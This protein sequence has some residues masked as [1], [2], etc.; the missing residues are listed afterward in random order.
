MHSSYATKVGTETLEQHE[1]AAS[2][3]VMQVEAPASKL[4]P[5][6]QPLRDSCGLISWCDVI[7]ASLSMANSKRNSS[8]LAQNPGDTKNFCHWGFCYVISNSSST[9]TQQTTVSRCSTLFTPAP[10][11]YLRRHKTPRNRE[12][13]HVCHL[14]QHQRTW[15]YS[16]QGDGQALAYSNVT[17]ALPGPPNSAIVATY[18]NPHSFQPPSLVITTHPGFKLQ[19]AN[20]AS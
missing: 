16:S 12:M 20:L 7:Y 10:V 1:G 8:G 6:T 3:H 19:C 4:S 18:S 15:L 2:K 13:Q 14:F 11:H 9:L 5:S 17:P